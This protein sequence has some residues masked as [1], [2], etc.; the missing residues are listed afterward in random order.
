MTTGFLTLD[1]F[2]ERLMEAAR[3]HL[4]EDE[5]NRQGCVADDDLPQTDV[6][7][8]NEGQLPEC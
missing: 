8:H 4:D 5:L 6:D 3:R 2:G 1:R 7:R